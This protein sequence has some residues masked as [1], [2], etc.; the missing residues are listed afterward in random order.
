MYYHKNDRIR[1][2]VTTLNISLRQHAFSNL[3]MRKFNLRKGI[4]THTFFRMA[5]F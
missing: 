4:H 1:R 5:I 3:F 2:L